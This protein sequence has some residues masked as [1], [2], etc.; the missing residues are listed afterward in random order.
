[1]NPAD[2]LTLAT[3]KVAETWAQP[4]LRH[5]SLQSGKEIRASCPAAMV[6]RSAQGN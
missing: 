2:M 5:R 1:M 4:L 6:T 3:V